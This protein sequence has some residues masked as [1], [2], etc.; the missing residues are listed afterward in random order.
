MNDQVRMLCV[1]LSVTNW[2]IGMQQIARYR[3][4]GTGC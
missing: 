3:L 1:S 4:L 2:S